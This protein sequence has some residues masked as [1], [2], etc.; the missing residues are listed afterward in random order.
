MRMALDVFTHINDGVKAGTRFS[1]KSTMLEIYNER[2]NDI[3][4]EPPIFDI[5]LKENPIKGF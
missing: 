5:K 2:V 4:A 1:L 3:L